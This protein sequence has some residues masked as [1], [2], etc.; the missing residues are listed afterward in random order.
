MKILV[1]DDSQKNLDAAK[2]QF[3]DDDLTV[4]DNYD[5]A[6]ELICPKKK[7]INKPMGYEILDHDFQIV[8]CDLM[9]PASSK[10]M[11]GKG[12]QFTGQKMHVG[13]FLAIQAGIHGPDNVIVGLLSNT[14]HHDHP[15]SAALDD[16]SLSS[17]PLGKGN[18]VFTNQI[19]FF[20]NEN[21]SKDWTK[22][23]KHIKKQLCK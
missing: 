1:V 9:M 19:W 11:G 13:I 5:D 18:A 22:F 14:D 16:F 3:K 12:M 2:E 23:L 17:F 21:H 20:E 4:I 6:F 8:L 15:G 7:N 10:R